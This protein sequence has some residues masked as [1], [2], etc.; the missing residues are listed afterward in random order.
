MVPPLDMMDDEGR[1]TE[2][3]V[4]KAFPVRQQYDQITA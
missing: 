3:H 2:F 1:F 4:A